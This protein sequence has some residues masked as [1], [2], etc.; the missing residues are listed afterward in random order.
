MASRPMSASTHHFES[1]VSSRASRNGRIGL[2]DSDDHTKN[3][4]RTISSNRNLQRS[5]MARGLRVVR[6]LSR[7]RGMT[8]GSGRPGRGAGWGGGA[9][10]PGRWAGWGGAAGGPGGGGGGGV[11][12]IGSVLLVDGPRVHDVVDLRLVVLVAGRLALDEQPVDL[13]Q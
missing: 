1:R 7:R 12:L 3:Q 11:R 6:S 13:G 10:G 4:N 8:P 5:H 9:G 2:S